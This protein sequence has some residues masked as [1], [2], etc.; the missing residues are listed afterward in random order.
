MRKLGWPTVGLFYAFMVA[1]NYA[2]STGTNLV[3]NNWPLC[4]VNLSAG[5]ATVLFLFSVLIFSGLI[6]FAAVLT[7][8]NPTL[9]NTPPKVKRLAW[10][11]LIGLTLQYAL[12]SQVRESG[13]GLA[14]PNFPNCLDGFLPAP[15]THMS[16]VVFMHRWWGILLL[17]HFFVLALN[18]ARTAPELARPTRRV[19]ALSVAQVFLGVGAVLSGLNADSR[20]F[21]AAAG[22]AIWGILVYVVIRSGGAQWLWTP[23]SRFQKIPTS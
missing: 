18:A 5:S 12:G 2:K 20:A 21:H 3:C 10:G 9:P 17:G 11:A 19:F 8:G 23:F 4:H 7:W 6:G 14:C 15:F 1:R 22:Y 13:A 16:G